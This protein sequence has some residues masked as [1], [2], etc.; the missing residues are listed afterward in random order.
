MDYWIDLIDSWICRCK[1]G[2]IDRLNK[3][4]VWVNRIDGKNEKWLNW[5]DGEI[6]EIDI[7][8]RYID[9]IDGWIRLVDRLN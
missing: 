2:L 7:F 8:D 4:M 9:C 1:P 5:I 3:W 6:G